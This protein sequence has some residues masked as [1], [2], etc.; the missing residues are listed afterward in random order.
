MIDQNCA[1]EHCQQH[2][3]LFH[4]G[5][6]E[7]CPK[8]YTAQLEARVVELERQLRAVYAAYRRDAQHYQDRFQAFY[9]ALHSVSRRIDQVSDQADR[10]DGAQTELESRLLDLERR[11]QEPRM[12]FISPARFGKWCEACELYTTSDRPGVRCSECGQ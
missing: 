3:I 2:D 11:E 9:A 5:V 10:L 7:Q 1:W 4:Y 8:C 6:G 12:V